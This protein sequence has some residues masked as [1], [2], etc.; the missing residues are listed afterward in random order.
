MRKFGLGGGGGAGARLFTLL[1][2]FQCRSAAALPSILKPDGARPAPSGTVDLSLPPSQRWA[3][4]FGE[5]IDRH[6]FEHTFAPLL[7]QIELYLAHMPDGKSLRFACGCFS[8]R[9]GTDRRDQGKSHL[10]GRG[11]VSSCICDIYMCR[12]VCIYLCLYIY[13]YMHAYICIYVSL[14]F[15]SFAITIICMTITSTFM[16]A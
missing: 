5:A 11:E 1:A 10:G 6:G 7:E 14:T 2:L 8:P 3:G 12:Y 4:V 15:S 13:E 9:S 16:S